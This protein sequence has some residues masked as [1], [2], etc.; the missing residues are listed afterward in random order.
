MKPK[1]LIIVGGGT[2]GWSAALYAKIYLNIER[3]LVIESKDVPII[4][5]GEGSTGTMG[6][7]IAPIGEEIFLNETQGSLK[8]GIKHVGWKKDKKSYLGPLDAPERFNVI[9]KKNYPWMFEN[10]LPISA[11]HMNA[12]LMELKNISPVVEQDGK[13]M[14][15]FGVA[16]HFDGH[17]VSQTLKNFLTSTGVEWT[18]DTIQDVEV[19]ETGISK[20]IGEKSFYV[21]EFYI[22]ATGFHNV[23]MKKAYD[24]NWISYQKN[25][26]VNAALP[27]ILPSDIKTLET[28][29]TA[30]AMDYGWMWKIPKQN[31]IGCGYVFNNDLISF[32]QAQQEV[33]S[34]LGHP[35]EPIKQ[36]K[37]VPGRL[38]KFLHKNCL[39]IGLCAA[40][41]EPLEATSI[42]STILQLDKWIDWINSEINEEQY[43][44]EISK[45]YDTYRDFIILHYKGGRDDTEFW[46]YQNSDVVN[47]DQVNL[48]LQMCK[49][50]NILDYSNDYLA[51]PLLFPVIYG[52]DLIE[53]IN[54]QGEPP[55]EILEIIWKGMQSILLTNEQLYNDL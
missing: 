46:K 47:T 37:F 28:Y 38:E 36:I 41:L 42:H 19:N 5:A 11:T 44:T 13:K 4:G 20:I 43:N 8:L 9:P 3:I 51:L 30:T 7:I 1:S 6:R 35:I 16:Y 34:L 26:S 52:L 32:N 23:L 2:A 48:I 17:L 24:I 18:Y 54:D 29:T 53:K 12:K 21:A 15:P 27:F 39:A 45:M 55:T 50:G 25:L 31:N 49:D 14:S 22:D 40:F 10:K 33:E